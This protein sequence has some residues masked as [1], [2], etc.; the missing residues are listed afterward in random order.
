MKNKKYRKLII[1]DPITAPIIPVPCITSSWA[2]FIGNSC[3]LLKN[4]L[5]LFSEQNK[6]VNSTIKRSNIFL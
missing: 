4:T 6:I 3:Y 2:K 1:T 5:I